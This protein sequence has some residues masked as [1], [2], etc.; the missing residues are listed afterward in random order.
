[1]RGLLLALLG[2]LCVAPLLARGSTDL[3]Q[4]FTIDRWTIDEGGLPQNSVFS[5][6]QAHDG[7]LWLGTLNGLVRFDGVRFTVYDE[8]NIPELRSSRILQLFED[9]TGNFWVGTE[10]GTTL[11]ITSEGRIIQPRIGEGTRETRVMSVCQD[12]LG[13][14]W[15]YAADGQLYRYLKGQVDV[16]SIVTDRN[17]RSRL[18]IAEKNGPI[19]CGTD[20]SLS[21]WDPSEVRPGAPL[22]VKYHHSIRTRLDYLRASAAGGYWLCADGRIQ[23]WQTNRMVKDVGPYPWPARVTLMA[24]CEDARAT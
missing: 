11:L 24:G 5:I 6:I 8:S 22:P 13:A 20:G 16:W 10:R 9:T 18:L 1:M 17:P 2:A 19:W 14:V 7:Y 15:L 3:A 21:G 23:R 4:R 12:S